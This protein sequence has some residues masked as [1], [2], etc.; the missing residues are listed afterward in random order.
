MGV[1]RGSGAVLELGAAL[2]PFGETTGGRETLAPYN[3]NTQQTR[4]RFWDGKDHFV[5]DDVSWLKGTHFFQFGGQYQHNWNYHERTDN[6][7][8][9]NYYPVYLLGNNSANGG[10]TVD[11]SLLGPA[12]AEALRNAG[13]LA[14]EAAAVLGIVTQTQQAYT[15]SGSNLTL[16]RPLVPA[17]DKVTIP[18]YNLYFGDTWRIKPTLTVNYGLGWTVEMPPVEAQWQANRARGRKRQADRHG[19]LPER[20]QGRSASGSGLQPGN[21]VCADRQCRRTPEVSLQPLLPWV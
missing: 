15:R 14:R 4:T 20:A 12:F 10:G 3:V 7:A 16:N 1:V 8:G 18:Y 9:I 11:Y 2:E 19:R 13:T 6:G 21:R 17:F 5:R